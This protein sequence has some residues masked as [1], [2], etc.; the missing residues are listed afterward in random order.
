M[1]RL[2]GA[3]LLL[4][5]SMMCGCF[6]AAR[7]KKHVHE[8]QKLIQLTDSMMTQL[9][10]SL[11]FISDLLPQ[12]ADNPAYRDLHFLRSAA[13]HADCFPSSWEEAVEEDPELTPE[14]REIVLTV[15]QTL[16]STTLE[17]QI[18]ALRLC[19]SQLISLREQAKT[20]SMQ[21][22]TLFRSMGLLC[23]IFL[24]ILLL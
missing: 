17:G 6:A 9:Q 10:S 7:L 15:G 18:S 22:G 1:M 19:Q 8:I 14:M 20:C 16:G 5:A 21:K 4:A 12:L 24:D 3:M 11:P 2:T 23:G 13:D